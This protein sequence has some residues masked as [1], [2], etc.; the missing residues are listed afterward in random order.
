MT[1]TQADSRIGES[2]FYDCFSGAVV[3]A[4]AAI[5]ANISVNDEGIVA[6]RN[7]LY[8]TVV[9]AGTALD[10]SISDFVSHDFPSICFVMSIVMER[11]YILT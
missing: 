5:N 9:C 1:Q 11:T 4:G 3:G 6:L 2:A 7:S 8:R 10:T